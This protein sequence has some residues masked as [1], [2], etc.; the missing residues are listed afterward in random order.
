VHWQNALIFPLH[1][2]LSRKCGIKLSVR[3]SV[4]AVCQADQTISS[5]RERSLETCINL[6]STFDIIWCS[7]RIAN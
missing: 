4:P 2:L 6:A 3:D 5:I 7:R 1:S